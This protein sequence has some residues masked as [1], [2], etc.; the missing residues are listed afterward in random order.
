VCFES[1][2]NV[3]ASSELNQPPE[4]KKYRSKGAAK[5]AGRA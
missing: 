3:A 2:F 4:S 1:Y 5:V